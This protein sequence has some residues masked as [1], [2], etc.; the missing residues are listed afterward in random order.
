MNR[1]FL[2]TLAVL[3]GVLLVVVAV[4]YWIIPAGS[5]PHFFPGFLAGSTLK[6]Y[7]HGLA[8]FIVALA[9]FAYAWFQTGKK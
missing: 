3:I 8:S 2:S 6:H 7:K 1:T 9:L 5:L 4:M